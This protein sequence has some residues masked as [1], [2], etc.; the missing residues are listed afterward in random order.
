[1]ITCFMSIYNNQV[2]CKLKPVYALS[3]LANFQPQNYIYKVV[4]L[5]YN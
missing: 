3:I 5:I 4:M 2:F 1:M